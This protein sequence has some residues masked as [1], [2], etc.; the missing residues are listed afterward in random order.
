MPHGDM[1][2]DCDQ[3]HHSETWK[4]D[5]NWVTF[6][7]ETTLFPLVGG[8]QSV[9][10]R[11]CH[12]SLDFS[13][14]GSA[15]IDCHSDVHQGEFGL[16]CDVCHTS[17][18]WENR[19][20]LWENHNSTLFPLVGVHAIID[21]EA[22]HYSPEKA[23]IARLPVECSGCHLE[24][25]SEAPNPSH[26]KAAFSTQ[27]D[28]CHPI[29]AFSWNKTTYRHTD[30][31]KLEG[32]HQ[33]APCNDCHS[34][35]FVGTPT[36][37]FACHS[38]DYQQTTDPNHVRFGF[39]TECQLCHNTFR[40]DATT[41]DHTQESG[42]ALTGAHIN[43][44]CIV[45]HVNNQTTGLP[46]DCYG[47]HQG[48]YQ[49]VTDPN[50]VTNNFDHNCE[51]CHSNLVWSP[52]TFDHASTQFPLSG[53]HLSVACIDCHAK[54]YA[55][56]PIDCYS[57]HGTDYNNTQNPNHKAAGFPN[58]CESCHNTTAW[59]Q[60]TW[61][62]DTQYFPIYSGRHRGEWNV[63]ADCHVDPNNYLRFECIFCHEH[64]DPR[65]L[66]NK[67][68]EV[69]NYQYS[70]LACYNCHPTGTGGD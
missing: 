23:D 35:T 3:C 28:E 44:P 27:C 20:E 29:N 51:T 48:D 58:T 9:A 13:K 49:S 47:C 25:Y 7:H 2:I 22:C 32:V 66:G 65:D 39:I 59:N 8:H 70:S 52:A 17:V 12:Q 64:N 37:C 40:W 1:N 68:R 15:C 69:P 30:S 63:C 4:V 36:V 16:R 55:G 6:K 50:H 14:I 56:T 26:K 61:N 60:T 46:R 19:Q 10:C 21:C 11:S 62:H 34:N 42:F 38:Q 54:G 53:A 67:H 57:C 5:L 43:L 41:F 18:N 33:I 31:F 45:C 24:N